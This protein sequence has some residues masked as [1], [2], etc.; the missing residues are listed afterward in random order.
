MPYRYECACCGEEVYIAAMDSEKMIPHF[1]HRSGNNETDCELYIRNNSGGKIGSVSPRSKHER[2][3][4]YFDLNTKLF[5]LSVCYSEKE[6][7]NC[8]KA[9]AILEIKTWPGKEMVYSASVNFRN[10]Y[11]DAPELISLSQ[12]SRYYVVSNTQQNISRK[13]DFFTNYNQFPLV[14]KLLSNKNCNRAKLVKGTVLYTDTEYIVITLQSVRNI[15]QYSDNEIEIIEKFDFTTMDCDFAAFIFKIKVKDD[16]SKYHFLENWG[17]KVDKRESITTLWPPVV[18]KDEITLAQ[19]DYVYLHST[20][21]LIPHG[22]INLNSKQIEIKNDGVY[23]ITANNAIIIMKNVEIYFKND[24]K[25]INEIE[26]KEIRI[27][28]TNKYDLDHQGRYFLFNKDGVTYLE[29]GTTKL[30]TPNSVIKRYTNNYLDLCIYYKEQNE[31]SSEELLNDIIA[32]YKIVESFAKND[33]NGLTISETALKYLRE[34]EK[35]GLINSAVK[36]YIIEGRV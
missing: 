9:A 36:R 12:F 6:I 5:L 24:E 1:R 27:I 26:K 3:E 35:S 29:G 17:F 28:K 32:N 25:H 20:S 22:N 10:F 4:I 31:V 34:C 13:Y 8:E 33:F 11:P 14:F 18:F 7:E 16:N 2:V 15:L 23:K 30:L 19:S 21:Q